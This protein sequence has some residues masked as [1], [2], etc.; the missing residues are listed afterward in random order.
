MIDKTDPTNRDTVPAILTPGEFV[1]NKEA[2]QMF[3]PVDE[4]MN[5]A[6]LQHRAMKNMGGGIQNYNDGG[7]AW[8]KNYTPEVEAA[9]VTAATKYGIDPLTLKTIV[10]L[11]SRG[12]PEAQSKQSSAGGI[13]QF[14]DK[15]AKSYNL[16]NRFDVN[17]SLDA[18][19]KLLTDNVSHLRS[20]LDREPTPAE[21]YLAHQQG[22][23]GALRLLKDPSINV[24]DVKNMTKDKVIKNGGNV[25]MTAGEF[26]NMWMQKA[27]NASK[28]IGG[29]DTNT[30]AQP[31]TQTVSVAP[32]T[33][34]P[35]QMRNDTVSSPRPQTRPEELVPQMVAS[36][37]VEPLAIE[38]AVMQASVP[39]VQAVPPS[40]SSFG[41]AFKD[42]RADMGA[43]GIFTFRGNDYTT[44]YAEEED[45]RMTANMGGA[46]HLNSGGMSIDRMARRKLQEDV[47]NAWFKRN[48]R[49]ALTKFDQAQLAIKNMPQRFA[50]PSPMQTDIDVLP[51]ALPSGSSQQ[52][53]G[54]P[55]LG[56]PRRVP[57]MSPPMPDVNSDESLLQGSSESVD[58]AFKFKQLKH[59]VPKP[60]QGYGVEAFGSGNIYTN[61]Q[62]AP[63]VK[64]PRELGG[65]EGYGQTGDA[66]SR[67]AAEQQRLIALRENLTP[68]SP[69][70][71]KVS[72]L[73]TGSFTPSM[74][75]LDQLV[76]YNIPASMQDAS[77]MM[78]NNV[79]MGDGVPKVAA[80]SIPK[81]AVNYS[82]ISFDALVTLANDGD[83]EAQDELL[84]RN[85][86]ANLNDIEVADRRDRGYVKLN[87]DPIDPSRPQI[88]GDLSPAVYSESKQLGI[89]VPE[90]VDFNYE[91]PASG[92]SSH[93][94]ALEVLSTP[95]LPESD[96]VKANEAL[97]G[98][99]T[100]VPP[101]NPDTFDTRG[102]GTGRQKFAAA[103]RV[104]GII[105]NLPEGANTSPDQ[106]RKAK[107][108][109]AAE[110]ARLNQAG[111]GDV[112]KTPEVKGAMS[113]IKSM[114]GDLFDTKE[115]ARAAILYLGGRATG[116]NGNQALAFAGKN[117]IARTDAKTSFYNEQATSGKWTNGS[118]AKYRKTRDPAD[119]IPVGA[120]YKRSSKDAEV[121]Y[122]KRTGKTIVYEQWRA[123]KDGSYVTVEAG[124]NPMDPNARINYS[125]VTQDGSN[126]V[127]TDAYN[128]RINSNRESYADVITAELLKSEIPAE[129][130]RAKSNYLKD[131]NSTTDSKIV[132]DFAK[133]YGI[134]PD[135]MALVL[136]N[137]MVKATE[138]VRSTRIDK[139]TTLGPY[140]KES[141]ITVNTG[142]RSNFMVGNGKKGDE[143]SEKLVGTEEF[144]SWLAQTQRTLSQL[145]PGA[146]LDQ[147]N[148]VQFSQKLMEQ[149]IYQDWIG[150]DE[151]IKAKYATDG[152]PNRSGFMEYVTENL[153]KGAL[154]S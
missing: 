25:D 63:V 19:G 140:L 13:M 106:D 94:Q 16:E 32:I 64:D 12:N 74:T 38:Q 8:H 117:Y 90:G 24:L 151:D 18:G 7:F 41:E 51:M 102:E 107:E 100:V 92:V 45:K 61:G 88:T 84:R 150:L 10:Y 115:L 132:S 79:P 76:D 2:T 47:D 142:D 75:S 98:P 46:V 66:T 71:I 57:P 72:N 60:G 127:G 119:L 139:V 70:H 85:D 67:R 39:Q 144:S 30:P 28:F 138:D 48:E 93:T 134:D 29:G 154:N 56:G 86:Q 62:D 34:I 33:S 55:D 131:I 58:R 80:S 69:E 133:K 4:Q 50:A 43:G 22:A 120:V 110:E 14:L 65:A 26:A 118:L 99:D 52:E 114:F 82:S 91:G 89:P 128:A 108:A 97:T 122:N 121:W 6:G 53:P 104:A 103:P 5:N 37:Q 129:D 95:N 87:E 116:L 135:T 20:V 9:I 59:G 125:M 73:I 54:M 68:G 42:A 23:T 137:A 21:T 49:D 112:K 1:L 105:N 124:K 136:R 83:A 81:P 123:G 44:N 147:Y 130:G 17:E 96:Y 36:N 111:N 141:Y 126:V 101:V 31:T 145:K 35:P 77:R 153:A 143:Y 148:P 109:A 11:E 113:A 3:G 40:P 146:N 15:T 152:S 27:N 78:A 149:A